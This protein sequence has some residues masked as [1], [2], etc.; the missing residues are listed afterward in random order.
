M[1]A[2]KGEW[3]LEVLSSDGRVDREVELTTSDLEIGREG[4]GLSFPD[5]PEMA[6]RHARL[7]ISREGVEVSDSGEDGTGVWLRVRG[8]D[9]RRLALGDQIWLG[10][11]VLVVVDEDGSWRLRHFDARGQLVET[12]LLPDRGL[13]IGRGSQLVLDPSDRA[14]SRRHAQVVIEDGGL[15]LYDRGA[16]NGTYLKLSAPESLGPGGEFRLGSQH[17]RVV[18][19]AVQAA[20]PSAGGEGGNAPSADP[21]I[22]LGAADTPAAVP[23]RRGL[24]ARLRS[25]G[26]S[27]ARQE[28]PL[29][30]DG[31]SGGS[32]EKLGEA[33][34]PSEDSSALHYSEGERVSEG[35]Q[36]LLVIDSEEESLTLEIRAGMTVLEAV[37]QAGLERAAPVDWECGDGGC[38]VCVLGVVEGA[39]RLDPP[40]PGSGEMKTIQ[41]TEQ[42]VPD[43]RK[44]R[45]A[46]LARVRGTVRLRR[47]T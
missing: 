27:R 6:N 13:F 16:H 31:P 41:I 9:G 40:D 29:P 42:V 35:E 25:L 43:P 15:V 7:R 19:R 20:D 24:A 4:S 32:S 37:Q 18:D 1:S 30:Q 3:L 39:D 10:S 44:Y 28:A 2:T 12:H 17:L 46:C 45:L 14:L 33:E 8:S 26:A 23:A 5:D 36:V 47:L 21:S 22:E 38:G 11:Q 34:E